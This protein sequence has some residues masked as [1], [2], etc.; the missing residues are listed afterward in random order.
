M[1]GKTNYNTKISEIESIIN[2]HN[3]DK[4]VTTT[5]LNVLSAN[6][7]TKTKCDV[8]LKKIS[9]K[10]TSNKTKE[11]FLQNEIEILEK[12]DAAYFR[13]KNYIDNDGTQN[14]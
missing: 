12:F 9:D 1:V 8:E 6:L 10:V 5:A 2:N 13:G 4:Y 7:I 11:S 3:H 14:Y